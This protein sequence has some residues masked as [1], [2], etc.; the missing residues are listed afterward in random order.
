M[1]NTVLKVNLL[2]EDDKSIKS[3]ESQYKPILVMSNIINYKISGYLE[4]SNNNIK[5]K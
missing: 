4:S 1:N 5:F 2:P 3:E